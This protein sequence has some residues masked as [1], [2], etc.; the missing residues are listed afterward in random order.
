MQKKMKNILYWL[1][2]CIAVTQIAIAETGFITTAGKVVD[3]QGKPIEGA[4]IRIVPGRDNVALSDLRGQFEITWS[5]RSLK[6]KVAV[7]YIVA[8]YKSKNLGLAFP[9]DNKA[10]KH[11]L[12]L[13][14]AV[15]L[16]G[17]VVDAEGK[18]IS[19][20]R[21]SILFRTSDWGQVIDSQSQTDENG[22]F[23][24]DALPVE[25]LYRFRAEAD[26][27]GQTGINFDTGDAVNNHLD[28]GRIELPLA[29]MSVTG[30]VVDINGLPVPG[31]NVYCSGE[32]QPKCKTK[33]DEQGYFMLDGICA[34]LVRIFAEGQVNGESV[35]SQILTEAGA[36]DV[37]SVVIENGYSRSRYIR[38][39][40]HEDIIKSGNPYI[41]GRVVDEDGLA[42][43]DVPVNVRF[44]R[45]KDENGRDV[46]L[47]L[48]VT[49]FGDVTDKQGRF[50]IEMEEDTTCSLLFSPN[51]HAAIIAYD[52]AT[53]T[54][55]LKVI[56]P[57]GGT[58]TG[59]LVS[60]SRGKKMP[61]PNVRVELKQTSRTSYSHI[62]F[63][64]DRKTITDPQGHYRFE[65]IRTLMR[66][67]RQQ[68][69]FG[70]RVWE[71]SYGNTS[72]TL[73]FLPG[74]TVKHI[75]L[76]IRPNIADAASLIGKTLLDFTGIN[77]DL[78]QDRLR[79]KILLICFFDY[80]QRPARHCILQLNGRLAQ[81][82]EQGLEIIAVQTTKT[83]E[84]EL[85]KW[86]KKMNVSIPVG[87]V[88][89]D[90]NDVRF[91]WNVQS[92]PW[93]ILTDRQHNVIAEGFGIDELNDK[94]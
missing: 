83:S 81:L 56:L 74:E 34:G 16:S 44:M 7:S 51:N 33:S 68:S 49:K 79:D 12:T 30:R 24:F 10:G 72:Q 89:G 54:K 27:Y 86:I 9:I 2:L 58:I 84:N 92:M 25:N 62:G 15:S 42:V 46:E 64:R 3:N 45:K 63:D 29:N 23:K 31:I 59:Q 20:V 77:I 76:V 61:V 94:I 80:A 22:V 48:H 21:L 41:A 5:P 32:G 85:D 71:L 57:D 69:V 73:M 6:G 40:S 47:Y 70:P 67:D 11:Q 75:D 66:S 91:N 8:R 50:A 19:G 90:I 17:S 4:K 18:A 43:A 55:D 60:L 82:K 14:P 52:I 78:S 88:T 26:G 38:T 35:S 28:L 36:R 53:G 93:L 87:I 1:F 13:K 65:H 39:K 37:K